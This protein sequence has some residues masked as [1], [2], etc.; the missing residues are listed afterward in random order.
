MGTYYLHQKGGKLNSLI[1]PAAGP[2]HPF[3]DLI[4]LS[5][6]VNLRF[7][8]FIGFKPLGGLIFSMK[9]VIPFE[10]S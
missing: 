8:L 6:S 5:D 3:T 7:T 4:N 10:K 2:Y 1:H 9:W